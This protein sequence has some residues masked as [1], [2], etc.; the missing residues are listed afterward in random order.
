MRVKL[1]YLLFAAVAAGL[2]YMLSTVFERYEEPV[3]RGWSEAALRNPFLAAVQ[4]LERGQVPAEGSDRLDVLD[5]LSTDTTLVIGNA[6][7]VLTEQKAAEL[8]TWME[9]GGHIIVAAQFSADEQADVLLSRF[10]ISKHPLEQEEDETE[11]DKPLRDVLL[12]AS[13]QAKRETERA[14][15]QDDALKQQLGTQE[16]IRMQEGLAKELDLSS[17]AFDG[18]DYRLTA[19]F[20]G[21]GSLSHPWLYLEEGE[22][23]DGYRPFYWAGNEAAI[24]FMQLNVGDGMLTV[25]ADLNVWTS[26]QLGFFDHA[27]LLQILAEN[28]EKV[29]FLYGAVVPSL[30]DLL[31]RHYSEFSIALVILL[32]AWILSRVRRFGPLLELQTGGRRSYR[33]HV[34][35]VGNFLWRQQMAEELM[36]AVR[37]DIWKQLHR[38]YPDARQSNDEAMLHRLALAASRSADSLRNLMLGP[39]PAEEFRFYQS[40]K[41]L[42][43][44]RKAL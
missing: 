10:K 5:E 2:L 29:V 3:D 30:L 39:V 31:W 21:S 9:R 37:E 41:T 16:R 19:D 34:Q 13:E 25:M 36:K 43:E 20:S 40:V 38:R 44:I 24:T 35:A 27:Y 6:N 22:E 11:E 33:E 8:L 42:Q 28:S 14:R 12:E 17:I 15:L 7:H 26:S 23:Y 18:L 4:F 1:W 32:A